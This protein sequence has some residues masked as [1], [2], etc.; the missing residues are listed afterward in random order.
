MVQ[1]QAPALKTA[2][3]NTMPVYMVIELSLLWE[4]VFSIQNSFNN[5]IF[6]CILIHWCA[7]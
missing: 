7:V 3:D 1:A 5:N 4:K 2:S 6:F